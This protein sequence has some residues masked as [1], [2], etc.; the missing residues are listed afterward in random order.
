MNQIGVNSLKAWAIYVK[1]RFP[2][3]VYFLLSGGLVLSGAVLG[4]MEPY[5]KLTVLAF[6]YAMW[7]FATLRLMDELKDYKK[8]L[9]A[10]PSRPLPRGLIKPKTVSFVIRGSMLVGI[11]LTA[12]IYYV[13]PLA[14]IFGIVTTVWLWLM[15]K[16]FY[17]GES[18]AKRPLFYA[19]THQLILIPFCLTLSMRPQ[20]YEELLNIKI[21]LWAVGVLGAFFTY[22]VS[23]KLDPKAHPVLQTYLQVYGRGGSLAIVLGLFPLCLLAAVLLRLEIWLLPWSVLTLLSYGLLWMKL[24][25]ENVDKRHNLIEG[26]ATLSLFFYIWTPILKYWLSMHLGD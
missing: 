24:R 7:L 18:L 22:E 5:S 3:P 26:L 17:I 8:D 15:Y 12:L 13:N 4:Y 16:E 1:E 19:I 2:L 23:R 20:G 14:G 25:N 21:V 9:V 10:H 6:S 11:L